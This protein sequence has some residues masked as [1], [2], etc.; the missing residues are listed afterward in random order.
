M[1]QGSFTIF[2]ISIL[3]T[4][5]RGNCPTFNLFSLLQTIAK[6]II[7]FSLF[8]SNSEIHC[9]IIN[10][11]PEVVLETNTRENKFISVNGELGSGYVKTYLHR[12]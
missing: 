11:T 4:T 7:H 10:Y 1:I 6:T 5:C 8:S 2:N 3:L 9:R 12:K